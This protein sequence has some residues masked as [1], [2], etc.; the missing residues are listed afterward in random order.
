MAAVDCPQGQKRR[1]TGGDAEKQAQPEYDPEQPFM[2]RAR[3]P[4][5]DKEVAPAVL[6]EEQKT[7]LEQVLS[8][9]TRT[10]IQSLFRHC[11]GQIISDQKSGRCMSPPP[12]A[13]GHIPTACIDVEEGQRWLRSCRAG[14]D[15]IFKKKKKSRFFFMKKLRFFHFEA[16]EFLAA[17]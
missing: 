6:N 17:T 4:W 11:G 2:L 3:Q 9:R 1:K 5:M 13:Q 15:L 8:E 12:W 10:H 14:C 7:Y 16:L